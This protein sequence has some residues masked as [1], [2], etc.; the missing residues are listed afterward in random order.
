LFVKGAYTWSKALNMTDDAG[1]AFDWNW[2]GIFRRNYGLANYD[3]T[4]ILQMAWAWEPPIGRGRR[5]L[6]SGPASWLVG[7]WSLNGVFYHFSGSPF[8][9]TASGASLNAPGNL[10]TA[11]LV[12]PDVEKLG[13]VGPGQL[14]F[15]P[16]PFAAVTQVRFGNTG[17][18][19]LRGPGVTGL[20]GSVFRI[21][22]VT[23]RLRL[24]FRAE[25]FNLTNTPRFNNPSA[26]VTGGN[27]MEVRS[28]RDDSDRQFRLGL[29][30]SF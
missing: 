26:N 6:S 30:L 21:F 3:R 20:D 27:F 18:N 22:P 7:N 29:K 8:S 19:I 9:V 24:E 1:G 16:T 4:H 23:E 11:D 14:Y 17:R 13:G 10:Q 12:K 5:W 25:A 28:T 15:D 2:P